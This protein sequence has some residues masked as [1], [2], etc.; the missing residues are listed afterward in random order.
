MTT[1]VPAA[2]LSQNLFGVDRRWLSEL[3]GTAMIDTSADA[4]Q[5]RDVVRMDRRQDDVASGEPRVRRPRPQRR[6]PLRVDHRAEHDQRR[7]REAR[8]GLGGH[9]QAALAPQLA[10]EQHDP[11]SGRQARRL[12]DE[13]GSPIAAASSAAGS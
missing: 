1:G 9:L 3:A 6:V 4:A 2:R 13:V 12:A 5:Q 8:H 7:I 10:Q 11:T